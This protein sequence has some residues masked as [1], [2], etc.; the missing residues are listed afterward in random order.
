MPADI[1][2]DDPVGTNWVVLG[3]WLE[4]IQAATGQPLPPGDELL[5]P[6]EASD[7]DGVKFAKWQRWLTAIQQTIP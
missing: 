7:S 1:K 3:Q 6:I 5:A 2:P 4:A